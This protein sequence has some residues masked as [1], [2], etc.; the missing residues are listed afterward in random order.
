[1]PVR[2]RRKQLLVGTH[3]IGAS[4]IERRGA[5]RPILVCR[6]PKRLTLEGA[7]MAGHALRRIDLL[8]PGDQSKIIG[9]GEVA[10]PT[11]FNR[12]HVS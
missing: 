3:P 11:P 6:A 4:L 8:P 1:M 12:S 2:H 7:A 5:Q 9:V 10:A